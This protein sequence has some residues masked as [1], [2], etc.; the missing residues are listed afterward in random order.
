MTATTIVRVRNRHRI[1]RRSV[2]FRRNVETVGTDIIPIISHPRGAADFA[3]CFAGTGFCSFGEVAIDT[4]G[5]RPHRNTSF[6]CHMCN[7]IRLGGVTADTQTV[8][9]SAAQ[10]MAISPWSMHVMAIGTGL[11]RTAVAVFH[12]RNEVGVLLVVRF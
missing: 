11:E 2:R 12:T 5:A 4:L 1:G 9:G 6:A 10:L 3:G 7:D 8:I